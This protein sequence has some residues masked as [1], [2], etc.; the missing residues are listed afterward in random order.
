MTAGMVYSA[1][2]FWYNNRTDNQYHGI[3]THEHRGRTSH[4]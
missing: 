1:V 4:R 3:D 2:P